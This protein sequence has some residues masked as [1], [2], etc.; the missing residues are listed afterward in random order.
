MLFEKIGRAP[1]RKGCCSLVVFGAPMPGE[2]MR[3]SGIGKYL[4][5]LHFT[6]CLFDSVERGL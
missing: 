3:A 4:D 5:I 6:H 2:R 1:I